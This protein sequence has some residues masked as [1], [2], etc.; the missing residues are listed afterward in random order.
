VQKENIVSL[1]SLRILAAVASKGTFAAAAD[2]LGLTQSAVSLQIKKLEEEF[3]VQLFERTGRSPR[4]NINGRLLVERAQEILCIYD[5]VK[6]QLSPSG[7]VK[8]VLTLGAVPTAITGSLPAVLGRLRTRY[9]DMHVKLISGLSTELVR[10][11]EEGDLDAALTTEPPYAVPPQYEWR[12]YDE[13]PFFVAAPKDA[14]IND[15]TQLFERFPFLRFDR[16][17]WAGAL[18]DR[19]LVAQGIHPREVMEFD[20]LEAALS[21]VEEGLGIAVVPLN[22]RRLDQVSPHFSL[23]PFA[24]PQLSRRVGMYQKRR[25]PRQVLTGTILDE[26]LHELNT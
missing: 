7:A 15:V 1:R 19:E 8:G 14:G 20:S 22:K 17:A 3:G 6:A 4:L 26:L 25:H 2:Q 12:Q 9:K 13:E 5:G 18:V 23:T 16:M 11:V 24:T 21:L 10:Q